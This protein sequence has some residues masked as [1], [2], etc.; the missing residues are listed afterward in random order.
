MEEITL[1]TVFTQILEVVPLNVLI[2]LAFIGSLHLVIPAIQTAAKAIVLVTPSKKDDE[3]YE[4]V[5]ASK[6]YVY[7][8]RFVQYLSGLK[9]DETVKKKKAEKK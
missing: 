7:F 3:V 4:K 8:V 6:A 2:V 5:V 9:L 1:A